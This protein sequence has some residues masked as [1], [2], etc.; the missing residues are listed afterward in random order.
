MDRE[1]ER[2]RESD[3]QRDRESEREV[4]RGERGVLCQVSVSYCLYVGSVCRS[5]VALWR[6]GQGVVG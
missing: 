6:L 2:E 1:R 3:R 4:V 5:R